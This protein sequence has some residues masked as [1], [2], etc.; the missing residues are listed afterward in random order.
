MVFVLLLSISSFSFWNSEEVTKKYNQLSPIVNILLQD[1]KYSAGVKSIISWCAQNNKNE[2]IRLACKLIVDDLFTTNETVKETKNI[3]YK[4][5]SIVDG[6]TI[7]IEKDW[8]NIS[9]RLIWVD[10][11]ESYSTR[12]W[13][14]E[15][16]WSEAKTYM[17]N[18][19]KHAS[20]I[21]LEIDITQWETDKYDRLLWYVRNNGVNINQ[22]MIE[23][24]YAREY[25]YN[26]PYKYQSEFKQSEILSKDNKNWLW[27]SNTCD[28]ERLAMY[29]SS[30]RT[31][32]SWPQWG[33]FYI[34]SNWNKSYVDRSLCS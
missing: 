23:D 11:P 3:I 20:T 13:Y 5:V 21:E 19:L 7:Q 22:K 9:V 26:K 10:A 4:L 1:Q 16:Y 8:K 28:W 29:V 30:N 12:F 27:A 31:Y 6:D 33:C 14:V 2:T 32:Y 18:L 34:N 24:W 15:C 17:E 25:T